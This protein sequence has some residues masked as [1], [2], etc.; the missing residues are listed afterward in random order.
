[1][2]TLP[3]RFTGSEEKKRLHGG[4]IYIVIKFEVSA[5]KKM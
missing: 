1:M 4:K 3:K 2:Q 5:N